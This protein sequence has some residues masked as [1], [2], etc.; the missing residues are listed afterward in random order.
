[1]HVGLRLE[2]LALTGQKHPSY[3][4]AYID[5]KKPED[6]I[7]FAEFFDGHVFVNEK[8]NP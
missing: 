2:I 6:V 5:F 8:G 3:A 4:R 7:E 1:M